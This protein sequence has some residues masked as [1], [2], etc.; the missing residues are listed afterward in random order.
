MVCA[1]RPGFTGGARDG[2]E[3][4]LTLEGHPVQL[5]ERR[6]RQERRVRRRLRQLRWASRGLLLVIGE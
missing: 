5:R 1:S 3:L 2:S 4:R 6:A